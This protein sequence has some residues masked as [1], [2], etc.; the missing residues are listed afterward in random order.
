[1][2]D[3]F[4]GKPAGTI[5]NNGKNNYQV[6]FAKGQ[7]GAR[8]YTTKSFSYNNYGSPE[9]AHDAAK[10]WRELMSLE[11]GLTKNLIRIVEPQDE[12]PYLEVQLQ[13]DFVMKCSIDDIELVENSVWTAWKGKSKKCWYARRRA[14][15]KL[16]QEYAMFHSLVCPRFTEV[17]HINRDGL[18]N[19][20][21]NLREGKEINARNKS[22][23][24]NNV[25][26]IK[27]VYYCS[28]VD[29][30]WEAQIGTG[31]DRR[32]KSFS[33]KKY[34]DIEARQMAIDTRRRW[35]E[36]LEYPQD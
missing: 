6:S 24:I 18:D 35:E 12:E 10:E 34:G 9:L 17:D 32:R 27:G 2:T 21:Q 13:D 22:M 19:R 29:A 3:W 36:E 28:T 16:G 31:N 33:T 1:M 23:Q 14:S 4:G 8:K 7:R 11:K 25:S 30:R 5:W 15:K 20:R 26:G